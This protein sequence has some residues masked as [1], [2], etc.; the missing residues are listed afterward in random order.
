MYFGSRRQNPSPE[1]AKH[2]EH[3]GGSIAGKIAEYH[4]DIDMNAIPP[5]ML[6]RN[7]MMENSDSSSTSR[8]RKPTKV[9][10][11]GGCRTC[12]FCAA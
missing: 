9:S 3:K 4:A 7:G 5:H 2:L 10:G 6:A 12:S 8:N 1:S 11:S